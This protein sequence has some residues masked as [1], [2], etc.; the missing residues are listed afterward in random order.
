MTA[1][2]RQGV[3]G[4]RHPWE[5]PKGERGARAEHQRCLWVSH[6]RGRAGLPRM[7]SKGSGEEGNDGLSP[8]RKR[9]SLGS[10][11]RREG[12]L[13]LGPRDPWKTAERW[14]MGGMA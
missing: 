11:E 4:A 5:P 10:M 2:G 6:G 7:T 9:G 1:A 13:T 14:K 12:G 8:A 3:H